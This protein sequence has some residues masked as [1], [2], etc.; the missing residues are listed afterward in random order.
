MRKGGLRGRVIEELIRNET[1]FVTLSHLVC[2]LDEDRIAVKRAME[3]LTRLGAVQV[4]Q[5]YERPPEA[6]GRT[7]LEVV[8]KAKER[9]DGLLAGRGRNH[10]TGWDRMWK[11]IRGLSKTQNTFTRRDLA[12]LAG[13]SM[14]NVRQFTKKLRRE[15]FIE[16]RAKGQWKL[17]RDPGPQR[18]A[19]GRL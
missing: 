12:V 6:R 1:R 14:E 4:I 2:A 11:A 8:Y 3:H 5:T 16:Q 15:G 17:V 7:V 19:G 13:V 10:D 18:P 9:L